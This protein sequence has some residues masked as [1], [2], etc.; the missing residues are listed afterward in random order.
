MDVT[1]NAFKLETAFVWCA[2]WAFGSA[3]TIT[4]DG[5]DHRKSFSDWWRNTFKQV[6]MPT[7]DTVFDYWLEPQSNKF[8]PWKA[9]PAFRAVEFNSKLMKMSDVTVPT[10]ETASITFWMDALT[11][12]G[13]PVMLCGG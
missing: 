1:S 3:L 7:R 8:E 10:T 11:R 6:R 2:I 13:A 12:L 4:D 5:T 9:S